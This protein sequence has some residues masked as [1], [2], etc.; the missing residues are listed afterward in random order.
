MTSINREIMFLY[1]E[2]AR[3]KIKDFAL[4]L[5]KSP[6]RLKY[7][8]KRMEKEALVTNPHVIFDYSY[9]GL[10]LFRVYFKGGYIGEKDKAD[11][12]K[13]LLE[14]G[15]IVSLY[16]L[17]GEY[18]LAIEIDFRLESSDAHLPSVSTPLVLDGDVAFRL[19]FFQFL[20]GCDDL[21]GGPQDQGFL[22]RLHFGRVASNDREVHRLLYNRLDD[23]RDRAF[24]FS[25][26]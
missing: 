22:S 15:Y 6:Q 12:I 7:T 21:A 23:C 17:L 19:G 11:I 10:I 8:L 25:R 26:H 16:E 2:N 1:A 9:F 18:D 20:L 4:Y 3:S 5:K 14:N 24:V 13:K